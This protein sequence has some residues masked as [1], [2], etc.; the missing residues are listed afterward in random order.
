MDILHQRIQNPRDRRTC[1]ALGCGRRSRGVLLAK[2]DF[3]IYCK[4]NHKSGRPLNDEVLRSHQRGSG[5]SL[6][7]AAKSFPAESTYFHN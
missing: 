2:A 5:R 7:Q 1:N 4:A 6:Q 3:S